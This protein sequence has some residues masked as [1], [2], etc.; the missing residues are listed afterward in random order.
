MYV[1][2]D[3]VVQ[4]HLAALRVELGHQERDEL[5]A[6]AV[7][8]LLQGCG[9]GGEGGLDSVGGRWG[10]VCVCVC[11]EEEREREGKGKRK[12]QGNWEG[13]IECKE[14]KND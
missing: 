13:I 8:H 5:W 9:C 12:E 1:G 7:T 14:G 2:H 4:R 6:E 3:E 11:V 10:G